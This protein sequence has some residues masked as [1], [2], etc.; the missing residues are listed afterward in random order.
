MTGNGQLPF[1][2]FFQDETLIE[3]VDFLARRYGKLPHEVLKE[4]TITEFSFDVAVMIKALKIERGRQPK[5]G[6]PDQPMRKL[7]DMGFKH[8]RTPSLPR[9]GVQ[10]SRSRR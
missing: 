3:V 7:S 10:H 4:I 9:A 6:Q 1:R 5:Q 8:S 2:A